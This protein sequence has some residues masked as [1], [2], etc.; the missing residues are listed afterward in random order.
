VSD[1]LSPTLY[2]ERLRLA[3]MDA[4]QG[5]GWADLVVRRGISEEVARLYVWSA[6]ARRIAREDAEQ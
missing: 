2:D 3:R 6:E 1:D 4:A 5:Y